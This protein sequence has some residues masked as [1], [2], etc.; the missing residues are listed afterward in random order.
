MVI[1]ALPNKVNSVKNAFKSG[2]EWCYIGR[3]VKKREKIAGALGSDNRFYLKGTLHRVAERFRRPYLDFVGQ[4]G[5]AQKNKLNWWASKFASKSP[6]QT[7]FFLM[8]CYK[9]LITE[10]MREKRDGRFAI[11][12][13]D[14]WL[15][16]DIRKTCS[17]AGVLFL[18]NAGILPRK[19]FCLSRG[20]LHRLFLI[21]W[22][23]IARIL[24]RFY[25]KAK[26]PEA[27]KIGAPRVC[28]INPC[29]IRAFKKGRYV[30]N[31][32]P[33]L[34]ELFEKNEVPFFYLY[35]LRFPVATA[36]YFGTNN[37]VL[38]PAITNV[39]FSAVMKRIFD[40]WRPDFS[41][42]TLED[43]NRKYNIAGLLTREKW[44]E[45]ARAG[46]NQHLIFFDALK[47]FFGKKWCHCVIYP[48]ENQPWEK[49]L[50]LAASEGGIKTIGFQHSSIW[51]FYL[52]QFMGTGESAFAPLPSKLIT[53]GERSAELY[54]KGNIP[55][56]II[57]VGG[58]L[59]YK[60]LAEDIKYEEYRHVEKAS[61][62]VILV[63]LCIDT[64]IAKSMLENII[65]RMS[66][67]PLYEKVT[68][69]IKPHPGN[70][71]NE[72]HSLKN[73]LSKFRAASGPLNSLLKGADAVMS[74]ASTSGLEAF[75]YGKKI[76][77]YVPEN[78]LE[79]DPLLDIEDKRISI[80]RE[81]EDIDLNFLEDPAP[82]LDAQALTEIKRGYFDKTNDKI[83]LEAADA[84]T[85]Y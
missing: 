80:W 54:R 13:E 63:S 48:F 45:N 74:S 66:D 40:F 22:I 51:R 6:M 44:L 17:G 37:R 72:L 75:L 56:N 46:F 12:V 53:S 35:P 8:L 69:W 47:N 7:D 84:H 15:F 61:K 33:G 38:W 50:C 20:L 31:Y 49:M 9:I 83:W 57:A 43:G 16:A 78:F 65:S 82:V 32:T 85:L 23:L 25:H 64:L 55:E 71:E 42:H 10:L 79:A 2:P 73:L 27:V 60:H 4:L 59:R 24:T 34:P 5:S 21:G 81:G 19:V 39:K 41:R 62:P 68:F 58:A 30:N 77:S 26:I 36:K 70:T 1:I 76:I 52:S 29:E 18:G 67:N 3:D 11:F 14:A 28:I